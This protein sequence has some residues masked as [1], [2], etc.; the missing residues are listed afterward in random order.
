MPHKSFSNR[1]YTIVDYSAVSS[2]HVERSLKLLFFRYLFI[3]NDEI[4]CVV[5]RISSSIFKTHNFFAF[6]RFGPLNN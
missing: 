5:L 1:C 4:N 6:G 2:R 3:T